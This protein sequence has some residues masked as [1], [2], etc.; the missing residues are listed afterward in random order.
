ML[1]NADRWNIIIW[2]MCY[3]KEM[4]YT[5]VYLSQSISYT[6]LGNIMYKPFCSS[7]F[8]PQRN[9]NRLSVPFIHSSTASEKWVWIWE[10]ERQVNIDKN[11]N[12]FKHNSHLQDKEAPQEW[13]IINIIEKVFYVL[14]GC[15]IENN[16]KCILV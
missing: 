2:T 14:R 16:T 8:K 7:L 6:L 15:C 1:L 11:T 9:P 3:S 4:I 13:K 10:Q 12:L 5:W